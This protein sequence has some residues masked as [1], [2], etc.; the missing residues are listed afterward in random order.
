MSVAEVIVDDIEDR[1]TSG[2]DLPVEVDEENMR[3]EQSVTDLLDECT[4]LL[5][6]MFEQMKWMEDEIAQ[7]QRRH[8][9]R[10]RCS[11]A[12]LSA[13]QADQ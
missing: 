9:D 5:G 4:S 13:V 11:L 10:K 7:A 6:P 3:I 1:F 12:Y 8:P 2:G